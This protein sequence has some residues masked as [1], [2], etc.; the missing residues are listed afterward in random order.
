MVLCPTELLV[1][2]N[3]FAGIDI[4]RFLD[5]RDNTALTTITGFTV[6]SSKH[7]LHIAMDHMISNI[8]ILWHAYNLSDEII[9]DQW[10]PMDSSEGHRD[11]VPL[12]GTKYL[13]SKCICGCHSAKRFYQNLNMEM[14]ACRVS[15]HHH[16]WIQSSHRQWA[17]HA[18]M[19]DYW[20]KFTDG[21]SEKMYHQCRIC[22]CGIYSP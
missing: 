13:L 20:R 18:L 16:L 9:D 10:T 3:T 14:Y 1:C 21:L 5:H 11:L 15:A 2:G 7:S 8:Q 17:F 12:Y 22:K 6:N 4:S 19:N